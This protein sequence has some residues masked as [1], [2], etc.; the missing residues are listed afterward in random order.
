MD[1]L[2]IKNMTYKITWKQTQLSLVSL[3]FIEAKKLSCLSKSGVK[4]FKKLGISL[5]SLA[6]RVM[7]KLL[8][9][10]MSRGNK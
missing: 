1:A 3:K 5:Y 10:S 8:V 2:N 6:S 7:G 4:T 9:F